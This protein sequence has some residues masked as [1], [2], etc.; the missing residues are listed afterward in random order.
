MSGRHEKE[1]TCWSLSRKW[2]DL[3]ADVVSVTVLDD[4][5]EPVSDDLKR[6]R[7]TYTDGS[8]TQLLGLVADA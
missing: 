4:T 7:F 6:V 8:C 1:A 2:D 5:H 3:M